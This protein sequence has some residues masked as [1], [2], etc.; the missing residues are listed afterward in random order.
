MSDYIYVHVVALLTVTT[1]N[2]LL[3]KVGVQRLSSE[4]NQVHSVFAYL[5]LSRALSL[6]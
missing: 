2:L 5:Y 1:H 4:V 6:V 3:P